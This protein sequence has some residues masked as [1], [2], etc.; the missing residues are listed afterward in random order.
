MANIWQDWLES[1]PKATYGAQMGGLQGSPFMKRYF[2][3]LYPTMLNRY[4]GKA[5]SIAMGGGNPSAYTFQSYLQ[6]FPWL[7]QFQ[8]LSPGERGEKSWAFSP[9]SRWL[10]YG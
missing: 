10:M 9:R 7:K 6:N 4:M 8:A 2:E 1:T 3:N 5:G